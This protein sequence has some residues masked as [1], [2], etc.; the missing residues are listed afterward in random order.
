LSHGY[1]PTLVRAARVHTACLN[2]VDRQ[3]RSTES[4]LR[5]LRQ[6]T[7]ERPRRDPRVF[8]PAGP[9]HALAA[10]VQTIS[11]AAGACLLSRVLPRLTRWRRPEP[12]ALFPVDRGR[13]A[14]STAQF[15]PIGL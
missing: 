3:T 2:V 10:L 5:R 12:R 4:K 13:T 9:T 11:K 6:S 15:W 14:D 8:L 1:P 7:R